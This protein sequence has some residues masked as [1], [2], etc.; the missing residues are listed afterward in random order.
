MV[1]KASAGNGL[2]ITIRLD[3]SKW[4]VIIS[5]IPKEAYL[6]QNRFSWFGLA[7]SRFSVCTIYIPSSGGMG[8]GIGCLGI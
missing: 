6:I 2:L 3:T 5:A 1:G 7:W 8:M 4:V